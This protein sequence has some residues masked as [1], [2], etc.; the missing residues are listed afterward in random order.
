MGERD[1]DTERENFVIVLFPSVQEINHYANAMI[2]INWEIIN[3]SFF[4]HTC[5]LKEKKELSSTFNQ[6]HIH[7]FFLSL[8]SS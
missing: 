4:P 8:T 2:S 7:I 3:P 1:R 5:Q 6:M